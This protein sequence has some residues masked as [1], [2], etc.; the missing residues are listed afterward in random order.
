ME[1]I[2]GLLDL[3][4]F[5]NEEFENIHA[6][7]LTET[8]SAIIPILPIDTLVL[9]IWLKEKP[10]VIEINPYGLSDPCLFTYKELETATGDIKTNNTT[11]AMI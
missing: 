2:V 4:Y 11:H 9:D 1:K 5:Y 6:Y 8:V 3:D 10:M 7:G